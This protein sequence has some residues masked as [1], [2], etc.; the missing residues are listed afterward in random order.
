MVARFLD[1]IDQEFQRF[2]RI[3]HHRNI[4]PDVLADLRRIDIDVYDL[5]L[6][7][8]PGDLAGRAVIETRA[9]IHQQIGLIERYVHLAMTVHPHQ[10]ERQRMRF[11]IGALT[12]QRER[13]R[14][15]GL[16][17]ELGELLPRRR[18]A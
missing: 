3:A 13:H 17:D 12:Q 1:Q 8:E 7:C 14:D 9:D 16:L 15:T 10:A 5:R 11:R 2:A 18:R 6:R 4:G